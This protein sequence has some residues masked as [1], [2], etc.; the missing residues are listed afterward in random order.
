MISILA[1]WCLYWG[2]FLSLSSILPHLLVYLPFS[3]LCSGDLFP[4]EE[5]LG[6]RSPAV[7]V[8]RGFS[9]TPL[10]IWWVASRTILLWFG[11]VCLAFRGQP[12]LSIQTNG[13]VIPSGI[14]EHLKWPLSKNLQPTVYSALQIML[15][16]LVLIIHY[17]SSKG[18]I[19]Y[20]IVY[21]V[22]EMAA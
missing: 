5:M 10:S 15:C 4:R 22:K 14:G 9:G 19:K 1:T 17:K 16:S 3:C 8:F 13:R 20:K 18:S 12:V 6:G 11:A 7:P 21:F 2:F